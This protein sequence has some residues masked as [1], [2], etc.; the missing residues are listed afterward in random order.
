MIFDR[1]SLS[2]R[3]LYENVTHIIFIQ[4]NVEMFP[5][6]SVLIPLPLNDF[7]VLFIRPLLP[8]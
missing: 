1:G 5:H 6:L 8:Y 4:I 3:T 7:R 2:S